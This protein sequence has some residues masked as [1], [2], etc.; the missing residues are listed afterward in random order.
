ME[1]PCISVCVIDPRTG[2]CEGCGRTIDEI[3]SWNRMTGA[4]RLRVMAEL[5]ARD[6]KHR[7]KAAG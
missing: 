7:L 6:G 3:S 2:L 1:T 4:E 5:P